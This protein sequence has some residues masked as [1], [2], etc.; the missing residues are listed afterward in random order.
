M[1]RTDT[2]ESDW[3]YIAGLTM[4]LTLFPAGV[5]VAF[6]ATPREVMVHLQPA[7]SEPG[8]VA[9][10]DGDPQVLQLP[11]GDSGVVMSTRVSFALPQAD[12]DDAPPP[13][14]GFPAS[15]EWSMAIPCCWASWR[16]C[17]CLGGHRRWSGSS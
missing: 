9:D 4:L 1:K 12:A 8:A 14:N 15:R 6:Q 5:A 7:T 13:R 17:A 3:L 16:R 2:V 11:G 10:A